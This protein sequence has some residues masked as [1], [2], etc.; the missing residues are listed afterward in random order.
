MPK[1]LKDITELNELIY[2]G[3]KLSSDKIGVPPKEPEQ[4]YKTRWEIW[5]E[6]PVNKKQVN[7]LE[8]KT[9][10]VWMKRLKKKAQLTNLTMKLGELNQKILTKER[11]VTRYGGRVKLCEKK[12]G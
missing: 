3:A 6:G 4:K 2:A 8:G 7:A 9:Q 12:M 11:R 1:T 10:G 5:V